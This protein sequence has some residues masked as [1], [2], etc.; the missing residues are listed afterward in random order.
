MGLHESEIE[1]ECPN[2][3]FEC[4]PIE[5]IQNLN[6]FCD[7]CQ[8]WDSCKHSKAT[9]CK[10]YEDPCHYLCREC[11]NGN[12]FELSKKKFRQFKLERIIELEKEIV[13]LKEDL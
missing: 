5:L 12:N 13:A 10:Y 2:C 8:R 4:D 6:G 1:N 3:C 9:P 11:K 7:A